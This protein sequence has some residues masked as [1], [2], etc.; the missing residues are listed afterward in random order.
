MFHIFMFVKILTNK[1]NATIMLIMNI[2]KYVGDKTFYKHVLVV[3]L[4]IAVQ[5]AITSF[6]GMLD[7]LMIGQLGTEQMTGVSVANQLIFVFNLCIF[8]AISGAG[9]FG[10]QFFGSGN[11]KGLR[12]TFRFKIVASILLTALGVVIFLTAG[13]SLIGAFLQGEKGRF[14][15]AA[16]LGFGREYLSVMMFG[17][18]PFAFTSCYSGTLRETQQTVVPMAAGIAAVLI[19]LVFNYILIFG[20]FGAPAMGVAG[21]AAATVIS[22]FAELAIVAVYTHANRAKTPSSRAPTAVFASRALWSPA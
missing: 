14:D 1:N 2:K 15:P 7:N 22:R 11:D 20:H 8:G 18:L 9:I 6:V 21:A 5:N 10:A 17:M 16:T 4:P 19:N 3:A 12:D 13:P